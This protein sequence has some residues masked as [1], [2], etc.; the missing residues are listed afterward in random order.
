MCCHV[1]HHTAWQHPK[2]G[3]TVYLHAQVMFGRLN[4]NPFLRTFQGVPSGGKF[5]V[6]SGIDGA[7]VTAHILM[8]TLALEHSRYDVSDDRRVALTPSGI[9]PALKGRALFNIWLLSVSGAGRA[10][11]H[12]GHARPP[13][14]NLGLATGPGKVELHR[15]GM[16]AALCARKTHEHIRHECMWSCESSGMCTHSDVDPGGRSI[17]ICIRRCML[18]DLFRTLT[19]CNRFIAVRD[20]HRLSA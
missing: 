10:S 5:H 17:P 11:R 19:G 3:K 4:Q 16:L 15:K 18:D 14:T 9:D 7:D 8:G 2:I 1:F 6:R 12:R 13:Y 20:T